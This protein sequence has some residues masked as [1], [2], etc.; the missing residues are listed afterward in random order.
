MA[1]NKDSTT[2][3]TEKDSVECMSLSS[4][5]AAYQCVS[6]PSANRTMQSWPGT[7]V[8]LDSVPSRSL[9]PWMLSII[10]LVE[11]GH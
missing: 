7:K 1:C 5:Q 6:C 4:G 8:R 2:D 3:E 10:T 11:R 9:E